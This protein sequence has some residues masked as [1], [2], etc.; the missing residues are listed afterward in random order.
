LFGTIFLH[1]P[2]PQGTR[3]GGFLCSVSKN[4]LGFQ[5]F[6]PLVSKNNKDLETYINTM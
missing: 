4:G 6:P 2:P 1:F 5:K 3:G